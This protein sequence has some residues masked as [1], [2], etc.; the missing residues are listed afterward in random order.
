MVAYEIKERFHSLRNGRA[1]GRH[2]VRAKSDT[3]R[4]YCQ[5]RPFYPLKEQNMSVMGPDID[6]SA[7]IIVDMQNDLS[8]RRL[9]VAH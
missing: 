1:S 9:A 8:P 6:K 4:K 5:W 3:V 7:M 2:L